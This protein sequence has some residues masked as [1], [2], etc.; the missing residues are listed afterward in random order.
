MKKADAVKEKRLEKLQGFDAL[1]GEITFCI[2]FLG[3]IFLV[4]SLYE[5]LFVVN[6]RLYSFICISIINNQF[7]GLETL[8]K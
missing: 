2:N 5:N 7:G 6:C 8:E 1:N 4:N 3:G